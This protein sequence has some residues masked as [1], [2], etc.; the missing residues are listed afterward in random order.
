ML[1]EWSWSKLRHLPGFTKRDLGN[2]R[3]T[4]RGNIEP[5]IPRIRWRNAILL[6]DDIRDVI[7]VVVGIVVII[8]FI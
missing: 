2:S 6:L 5:E 8:I 4:L 3:K 7:L 1:K